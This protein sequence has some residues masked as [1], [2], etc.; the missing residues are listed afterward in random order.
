MY[1]SHCHSESSNGCLYNLTALFIGIVPSIF[2]EHTLSIDILIVF[3]KHNA[4]YIMNHHTLVLSR[5]V[6]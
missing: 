3:I 5:F 6:L 1:I 4:A 2:R